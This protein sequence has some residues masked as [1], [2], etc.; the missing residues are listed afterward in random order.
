MEVFLFPKL[1]LNCLNGGTTAGFISRLAVSSHEDRE[2][3]VLA[4]FFIL[5]LA[6][7]STKSA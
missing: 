4:D 6:E 7:L 2:R 5:Y 3:C 1:N